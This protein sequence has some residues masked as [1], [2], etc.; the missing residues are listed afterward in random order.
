MSFAARHSKGSVF[1]CNTEGF[2]YFKLS[3]LYQADGPGTVYPVQG[4]YINHKSEYGDAPVAICAECFVN[5]PSYM[6]DEVTEIL[7]NENDIDDIKAGKVGFTIE[8]YE[9]EIGKKKKT[10]YGIRWCDVD[11]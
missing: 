11:E 9:K 10:C 5:F 4:L 1:Q 8:S 6:M 7:H 2:K 3:E